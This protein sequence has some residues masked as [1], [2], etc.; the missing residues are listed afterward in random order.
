[1]Q[2]SKR[3]TA[4]L[5]LL[6][7]TAAWGTSFPL[8]KAA[9]AAM[10]RALP[11]RESW[12]FS[13]LLMVARFGLAALI[14]WLAQPR[15]F[16]RLTAYEWRQGIGLGL[17][18]ALG[19]LFQ[20]NALGYS[21]ASTTAFL[22][23]FT[24]VLVPLAVFYRDRRPPSARVGLCIAL[25]LAGVAVLAQFD[26]HTL[27]LGRGE[28][29][30]LISAV[31]FTGQIL[32]LERGVF[33]GNDTHRVSLA[34]FG[35]IALVLAPVVWFH[36]RRAQDLAVLAASWPLVAVVLTLTLLCSLFAFLMMNRWQPQ[37]DAT[38][39]GIVYCAEPLFATVFALF[40]PGW[41]A[42]FLGGPY[43][44]EAITPHLLL[45]GALITLANFL[46]A[47]APRAG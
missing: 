26:W 34:M 9:L 17:C 3:G 10:E 21:A 43:A 47:R 27:R 31:F 25:V 12:F 33:H 23:Q 36:A 45:G 1:M 16:A 28:G 29:E 46:I 13:A 14:L 22:T 39:A 4:T 11:G 32:W 15:A 35:T 6:L 7:T 18:A 30:T 40:L 38:T 19:M 5:L 42:P 37:V 24:C 41:I 8:G 2:R 44:N 20:A